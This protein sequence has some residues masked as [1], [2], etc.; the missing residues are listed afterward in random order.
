[1]LQT[2]IDTRKHVQTGCMNSLTAP[3]PSPAPRLP[4]Q[5]RTALRYRHLSLS[6]EKNYVHWVRAFIRFHG[7]RHPREMGEP[8]VEVFLAH[9]AE[10]RLVAPSTHKQALSAL[11]FLY[12]EVLKS[13]LP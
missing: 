1:M 5:L 3:A 4:D 13:D 10:A 2:L 8:E 6:T 11:L 12:R 9:L 7:L